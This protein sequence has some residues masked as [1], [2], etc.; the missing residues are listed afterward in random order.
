MLESKFDS[1]CF[2]LVG[3]VIKAPLCNNPYDIFLL[4]SSLSPNYVTIVEKKVMNRRITAKKSLDI[5]NTTQLFK[6]TVG[7][8]EVTFA[9]EDTRDILLRPPSYQSHVIEVKMVSNAPVLLHF[10]TLS[11]C[12]QVLTVSLFATPL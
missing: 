10:Y 9:V 6:Y 2:P 12:D 1:R 7:K 3:Y 4:V 8:P 5:F 11:P